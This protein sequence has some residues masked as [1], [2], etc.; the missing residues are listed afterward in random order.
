MQAKD[1]E[2]RELRKEH[3]ALLQLYGEQATELK[4]CKADIFNLLPVEEQRPETDIIR[5]YETVCQQIWTWIWEQ[6]NQFQK[7]IDPKAE[8]PLPFIS[9]GGNSELEEFL[10][11][12]PEADEHLVVSIIHAYLQHKVLGSQV[13][14]FGANKVAGHLLRSIENIMRGLMPPRGRHTC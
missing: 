4:A 12:A 7:Y 1:R 5:L 14:Y 2:L 11:R 13:Y 9:D 10:R 3:D 8:N 6:S